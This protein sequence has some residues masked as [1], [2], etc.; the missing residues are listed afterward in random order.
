MF[1]NEN[2]TYNNSRI[3]ERTHTHARPHPLP[4]THQI[5]CSI[6]GLNQ[7]VLHVLST[8]SAYTILQAKTCVDSRNSV[9][10]KQTLRY[11]L[12]MRLSIY[13]VLSRQ[14]FFFFFFFFFHKWYRTVTVDS[15]V[16]FLFIPVSMVSVCKFVDCLIE[17][18]SICHLSR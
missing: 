3:I 10:R 14:Y 7:M 17:D 18:L 11:H 8:D 12:M 13:S 6:T 4:R 2:Y 16:P 5:Y 1:E 15:T 9:D